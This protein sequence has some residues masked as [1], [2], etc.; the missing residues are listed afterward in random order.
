VTY[1]NV[2]EVVAEILEQIVM[3]EKCKYV[4]LNV[5]SASGVFSTYSVSSSELKKSN[6]LFVDTSDC[7]DIM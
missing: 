4:I 6:I 5:P 3:M 1:K 2:A 7:S